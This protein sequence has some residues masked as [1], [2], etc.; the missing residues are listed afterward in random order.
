MDGLHVS[1]LQHHLQDLFHILLLDAIFFGVW[2]IR[3]SFTF[4]LYWSSLLFQLKP[5]FIKKLNEIQS[6]AE[7]SRLVMRSDRRFCA[8]TTLRILEGLNSAETRSSNITRLQVNSQLNMLL[9]VSY[10]FQLVNH[11]QCF[12]YENII[13][14]TLNLK[15]SLFIWC[16][17]LHIK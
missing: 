16:L 12:L 3:F 5:L 17:P 13:M 14:K 6:L 8:D 9:M 11:H 7:L 10:M 2:R 4:N 15:L 1:T